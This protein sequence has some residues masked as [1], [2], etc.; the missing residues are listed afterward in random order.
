MTVGTAQSS[1]T[2]MVS[3]SILLSVQKRAKEHDVP[4]TEPGQLNARM[5][6]NPVIPNEGPSFVAQAGSG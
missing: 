6:F 2:G 5:A 3:S 4:G 1:N